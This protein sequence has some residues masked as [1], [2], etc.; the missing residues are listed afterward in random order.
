MLTKDNLWI[1]IV[2]LSLILIS[3]KKDQDP[4]PDLAKYINLLMGTASAFEC[5]PCYRTSVGEK[6]G[7]AFDTNEHASPYSLSTE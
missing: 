1:R 4:V 5:S 6:P 2:F 7:D 3:C